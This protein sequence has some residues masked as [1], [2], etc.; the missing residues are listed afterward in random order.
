MNNLSRL[1]QKLG[2]DKIRG[3]VENG[4]STNAAKRMAAEFSFVTDYEFIKE[5]LEQTDE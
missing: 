3:M 4:C 1:E 2:F 5:A